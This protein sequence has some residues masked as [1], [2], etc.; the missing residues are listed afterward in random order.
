MGIDLI[1]F[2][3]N[4]NAY[5]SMVIEG[6][7]RVG[8][9]MWPNHLGIFTIPVHFAVKFNVPL[10][11]WGENPQQEYGGPIDEIQN[12]HLNRRWLEEFGGLLGNRIQD[13]VGV[14]GLTEKDLTPYF[15]PSD[16]DINRVGVTGIFLGHYFFW[17]AR[18]QLEIV[19]KHGFSV[20]EDGPV[21]GTY[22]NYENLDEKMHSLHDYLKFV[23]YGF[24]RAT[25]HACIDIRNNR[26]TREEALKL[27]K[28][29]D[30]KYPHI[31]IQDFI[32]YSGMTK[33]EVDDIIDSFTN[34]VLFKQDENGKFLRDQDGNLIRN[35][36]VE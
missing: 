19:M 4:Y 7:K 21:E 10:I 18:K 28:Q 35:F 5:K 13:M 16:E 14:D 15:Y 31:G 22:T 24:A 8:D 26:L 32:D 23:K 20:K 30:G 2:K 17:D 11:I 25:D 9:E 27:V 6:F 12:K 36:E 1:Y 34:P 33:Q 29:Y 3:K